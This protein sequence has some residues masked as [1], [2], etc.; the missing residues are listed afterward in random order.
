MQVT[1]DSRRRRRRRLTDTIV[2]SWRRRFVRPR[3]RAGCAGR[4][5]DRLDDLARTESGDKDVRRLASRLDR[6][7]DALAVVIRKVSRGRR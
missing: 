4:L 7:A 6:H 5:D 2:E 1:E 3:T